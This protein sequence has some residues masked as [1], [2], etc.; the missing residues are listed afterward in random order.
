M[1]DS[2]EVSKPSS[3]HAAMPWLLA[4]LCLT[5]ALA[6]TAQ[7]VNETLAGTQSSSATCRLAAGGYVVVW[8]SDQNGD[9][10]V[11][12]RLLDAD[13][14]PTGPETRV[15]VITA[16]DQEAPAV[17]CTPSGGFVV[18]WRIPGSGYERGIV[19]RRFP[20]AAPA[21]AEI[22]VQVSAIPD[23][24]DPPQICCLPDGDFLVAWTDRSGL[25][26][27]AS[28]VFKRRFDGE[29][30]GAE[31]QVNELGSGYQESPRI[32]C[33]E[34]GGY[35][36]LWG[37]RPSGNSFALTPRLRL[38]SADDMP[39]GSEQVVG[40]TGDAYS[41]CCDDAGNV[42]VVI[43]DD[44]TNRRLLSRTFTADGTPDRPE[45]VLEEVPV[46]LTQF[47]NQAVIPVEPGVCCGAD[48]D[49][50]VVSWLELDYRH[51]P[52]LVH[53]RA[54]AFEGG[55]ALSTDYRGELY[56]FVEDEACT[57]DPAS[58]LL[59][60]N[61]FSFEE[62][63]DVYARVISFLSLQEIPTLGAASLALLA[64]LLALAGAAQLLRHRRA[65]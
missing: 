13:A 57:G 39:L 51:N 42:R 30:G 33:S 25:D 6:A 48:R 2:K 36:L 23:F 5:A 44:E 19:A 28:G 63:P 18:A 32:C 20:A 11:F 49:D 40:G 38:F 46:I 53:S 58:V 65:G 21:G 56:F 60:G 47:D 50:F 8:Q 59:T 22:P 1:F 7:P 55:V 37:E 10:D 17:C 54:R 4:A 14:V 43:D 62:P 26:G 24:R 15:N 35:S 31:V 45:E 61:Q 34:S 3:R 41:Q 16:G 12:Y 29:T 64:L 9:A 27:D 52:G